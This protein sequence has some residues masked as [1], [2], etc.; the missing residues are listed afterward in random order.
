M[1]R[2]D[3]IDVLVDLAAHSRGSRLLVFA[4]KPA[5]VQV[6]YLAYCS[7]TG[8]DAI[9]YRL[10][11]PYL[12][13]PGA[14]DSYYSEESIRLPE[15]YWCY[16]GD[17]SYAMPTVP[18]ATAAG[19]VTFGCLNNWCKATRST[20]IAWRELLRA[21]PSS[22]LMLHAPEGSVREDAMR[23][24]TAAGIESHRVNFV[25][26]VSR[27]KYFDLYQRIDIALDPFPFTGGTTTCDALWMGVPVVSLV[28][29]TA[30]S[31]AGLSILSNVGLPELVAYSNEEYV[32]RA[33]ELAND[34]P[35]LAHLRE[36]LRERMK[37]SPLMDALRFTKGVEE[38]FR[39]MWQ[40]WC[41]T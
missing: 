10:S 23:V 8:L 3:G 30:V 15:T 17:L 22:R 21:I 7:T 14:V 41:R 40:R 35:R 37:A 28:G 6:T 36:T 38:A 25:G 11:D 24:F 27:S 4:R 12:D 1:I 20:F 33:C 19:Y 18:P 26:R 32:K 13:P 16:Q 31:R 29:E 9:D 5:P 2:E 39:T 34:L